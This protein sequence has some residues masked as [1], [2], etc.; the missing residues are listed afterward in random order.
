MLHPAMQQSM[1]KRATEGSEGSLRD[2]LIDAAETLYA[3]QGFSEV[4]LRQI[5]VAAGAKNN[6]AVQYYF[7]SQEKLVDAIVEKRS[8]IYEM[9]RGEAFIRATREAPLTPRSILKILERPIIDHVDDE[10]RPIGARFMVALQN[11]SWGW[12]PLSE[13][14]ADAPVTQQLIRSL[15]ELMPHLPP[16]VVWQRLY[17]TS[18][19]VMNCAAQLPRYASERFQKAVIEN[20]F[21]MAA[22]ALSAELDPEV[23]DAMT[24][25]HG[26]TPMKK[27]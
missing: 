3:A 2:R 21:T 18:L 14:Y 15:E 16:P 17:L 5:C 20:A 1:A 4:S 24:E 11:T 25:L 23:G 12:K 27:A 22:A 7:G 13:Q 26:T 6:F 19:L 9:K 8:V 10:G